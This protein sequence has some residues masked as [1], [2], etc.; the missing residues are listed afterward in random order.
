[1]LGD[2]SV[3]T[4]KDQ[5]VK[6]KKDMKN[7]IALVNRKILREEEAM[8]KFS[9]GKRT[10]KVFPAIS[11]LNPFLLRILRQNLKHKYIGLFKKKVTRMRKRIDTSSSSEE[12]A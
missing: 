4:D 11:T 12:S 7:N 10:R 5:K 1:V 8:R 9:K 3:L 6:D 2:K